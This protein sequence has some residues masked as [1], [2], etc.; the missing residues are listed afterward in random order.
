MVLPDMRLQQA[1]IAL[2]EELH[3]SIAAERLGI[4]QSSLSKRILELESLVGVRLFERN[5]QGVKLTDAGRHFVEEARRL[6]TVPD[7]PE[8]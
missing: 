6:Y 1:A 3:F 7:Q 2:A 5:H 4:E 8:R